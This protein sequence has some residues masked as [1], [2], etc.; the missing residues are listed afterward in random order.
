ML[1][2]TFGYGTTIDFIIC[3]A[4]GAVYWLFLFLIVFRKTLK[5]RDYH[6]TNEVPTTFIHAAGVFLLNL[7]SFNYNDFEYISNNIRFFQTSYSVIYNIIDSC[8]FDPKRTNPGL[9][10]HHL[11]VIITGLLC[12]ILP[13]I[14]ATSKLIGIIELGSFFFNINGIYRKKSMLISFICVFFII[15][16][17][18]Y[19]IYKWYQCLTYV[20]DGISN[21]NN[22]AA[23]IFLFLVFVGIGINIYMV[24]RNVTNFIKFHIIGTKKQIQNKSKH[25]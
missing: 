3:Y 15:I 9:L 6:I 20:N 1:L 5:E 11:C 18:I 24:Y 22:L 8:Y 19:M 16:T 17:R 12:L 13:F 23:Y 25:H 4:I 14:N 7:I 10:A 21:K 2:D